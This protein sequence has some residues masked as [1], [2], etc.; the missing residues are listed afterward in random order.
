VEV[1]FHKFS[2]GSTIRRRR[3]RWVIILIAIVAK[4]GAKMG[5]EVGRLAN[6]GAYRED[7]VGEG[8]WSEAYVE[9]VM[10]PACTVR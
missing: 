2:N 9:S 4:G 6:G 3:R 1:V 8:P 7:D 10:I 5:V